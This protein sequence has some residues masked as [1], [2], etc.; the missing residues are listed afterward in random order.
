MTTHGGPRPGS[1]RKPLPPGQAKIAVTMK[2]DPQVREYLRT[3]ENATA[4]V[5][6]A[7]MATRKFKQW[8][9]K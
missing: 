9:N 8:A 2:I 4:E 6:R 1:G 7:V 3:L 5:E